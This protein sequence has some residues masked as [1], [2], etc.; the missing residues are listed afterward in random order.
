MPSFLAPLSWSLL[1]SAAA[2]CLAVPF[3]CLRSSP[4]TQTA[5]RRRLA[6]MLGTV[7]LALV[8]VAMAR[9]GNATV[10]PS[11]DE[12]IPQFYAAVGGKVSLP[13][14]TSIPAGGDG[15]S[16]ILWYHGDYGIPIYSLDARDQPLGKARHFPG[17]DLGTRAYLD[18]SS[19]PPTLNIDPVLESDAG[20]YRCRVDY[21]R[22][23]T[24]HRNVNLTVIVPPK[25]AI[26][27]DESG[28]P[29]HGVI[30]PYD[31]GAHLVLICDAD[32]GR[33]APSVTWWRG[34]E[35]VDDKYA[36]SPLDVVRNELVIKRL[37]RSDLLATYTCQASNT[38]L[39]LPRSSSVTI[40][41]NLRPLDVRITTLKRP[42]SAHRKVELSCQSTGGRPA[43]QLTWWLGKKKLSFARDNVS[44]GDN[45]TTSTVSFA[46]NT[47]DHGKYLACR[48]DNPLLSG[49]GLEDGWTL[50][51]Q[52]VPRLSL[53]LGANMKHKAI[54]EG[55]DVY[56]ECN[57][58]ANPAVS[59]V[60]WKFEGKPLYSNVKQGVII[61][62]QSLVLQ[63]VRRESRGHYQCVAA[64]VEGEGES[65]RVLLRVHYAPVCKKRQ[66]LVY[67]VARDEEAEIS[68]EVE[69]D[70]SELSFK[71]AL[72]NSVEVFDV[73]TFT[74]NGTTS[75]ASYRP[76]WKH[77]YGLLYCWATNTIGMQ[78]EPCAFHII[79]AG[80]P[81][82]VR[83]CRVSNQTS[84]S[85]AVE[86]EPGD[87]GGLRQTFHLE[88]YNSALE[89][90]QRNLS[91]SEGA[92]FVV[93][94]LPPGTAFILVLYGSNSKGR[95]NSVSISTNTLPSPER[96]TANTDI[97][98]VS[99]VLGVLIGIVGA[100]VL[101]AIVIV[102]VMRLRGDDSEKR[103]TE[104]SPEKNQN[105][106]RKAV[107]DLALTDIDTKDPSVIQKT[108]DSQ[109]EYPRVAVRRI[110]A[111]PAHRTYDSFS[112]S[113]YNYENI[114]SLRRPSPVK[115][116]NEVRYAELSLPRSKYP[117]RIREPPTEYAQI[118]FQRAGV[119]FSAVPPQS[120]EEDPCAAVG[121][122]TPLMNSLQPNVRHLGGA[123]S[124]HNT[125]STPV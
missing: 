117:V 69:A 31:E 122:D 18:V 89:L 108:S 91:S 81:E 22:Q 24:Q 78:R 90:L 98:S 105:H 116:D 50:N 44:V 15:V 62:N 11:D 30:G 7:V 113:D 13:C 106:Q 97:T 8:S 34:P 20:E 94:D 40:N 41:M 39:T 107:D 72:N 26:I 61:S 42:L 76:R 29:L 33:P 5:E 17:Q 112:P 46:P 110:P 52:Y 59:E 38:N 87:H 49:A 92:S 63:K 83:N 102:V 45:V 73:K 54:R 1:S 10:S 120:E 74:V 43:P 60:G 111:Y 123:P 75:V 66:N 84:V 86:C 55:S 65:D 47:D 14:N 3:P 96:R 12:A 121:S 23:R 109:A 85:L 103:P 37:Q 28:K 6:I 68:C 100:L 4:T 21:S 51:I 114:Q 2:K 88:V 48:A 36:L 93:R 77:S 95:S 67:G 64:N 27:R 82:A 104:E 80:P 79:P 25:D 99:P 19:K 35:L 9:A 16:L 70:P 32:G 57:I 125:I 115:M 71:W 118:D 56:L 119:L 58:Q 124:D 101:V 53:S